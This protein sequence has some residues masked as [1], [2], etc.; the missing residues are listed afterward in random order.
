LGKNIRVGVGE[1]SMKQITKNILNLSSLKTDKCL[2]DIVTVTSGKGG[3]GKTNISVNLAIILKQLKRNVLLIDADINLGNV[4]LILGIRPK[5]TIAD[6]LVGNVELENII[7]SG[8]QGI[9]ILPAASAVQD[10]LKM[11]D[12]IIRKLG[13]AFS[14]LEHEYDIIVVDTGSGISRNVMS[15]V[16]GSDKTIVIVTPDPASITDAYGMIKLIRRYETSIPV[17]LIVNM[18]DSE[19]EGESLYK[20]M[21]LM[22]QRFLKSD[23]LYGGSILQDSFVSDSIRKQRPLVLEY[24]NS[25]SVNALKMITRNLLRLPHRDINNRTNL[26]NRLMYS[27]TMIVGED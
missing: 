10:L 22:V 20:K 14:R 15:F 23:I 25:I 6:A 12:D 21:N 19:D 9:D 16:L 4:N 3:V 2:P 1:S 18:V 8:T 13:D 27:R 26:F 17:M 5:Y 11:E 24:P 7:V